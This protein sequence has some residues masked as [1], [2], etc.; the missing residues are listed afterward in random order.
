MSVT[1]KEDIAQRQGDELYSTLNTEMSKT[2]SIKKHILRVAI[3]IFLF[4]VF[5]F[6]I[7]FVLV[8][9][10]A[11]PSN[12]LLINQTQA[13]LFFGAGTYTSYQT[14]LT[15]LNASRGSYIS[16]LIGNQ[17]AYAAQFIGNTQVFQEF[18][19]NRTNATSIFSKV[20]ND[21]SYGKKNYTVRNGSYE[22]VRYFYLTSKINS[23]Y[24]TI[25]MIGQKNKT[26]VV[27]SALYSN[28]STNNLL[29]NIS[30]D[31]IKNSR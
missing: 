16:I 23:T 19:V 14:N 27:F 5:I 24:S 18:I 8:D 30:K 17:T 13:N 6:L 11:I 21:M 10:A 31:L 7:Y 3:S 28:M 22:S 1:E 26:L 15:R 2:Y 12:R 25:D 20:Y 4:I 9:G 29:Q